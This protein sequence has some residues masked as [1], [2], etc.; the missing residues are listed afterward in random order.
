VGTIPQA[1]AFIPYEQP[2]PS[3]RPASVLVVG[4]LGI[5][6]ASIALAY[7]V[8]SL[9]LLIVLSRQQGFGITMWLT[10]EQRVLDVVQMIASWGFHS[11]LLWAS[12]AAIRL[13]PWA[14]VGL[15]RWAGAYLGWLA[16]DTAIRAL[17]V[18]PAVADFGARMRGGP[19]TG[20][21][22]VAY[23]VLAVSVVASM[24]YPVL[25][26]VV[27]RLRHVRAEFEFDDQAPAAAT[28][29]E[30]PVASLAAPA[31]AGAGPADPVKV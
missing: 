29:A 20:Q 23:G 31:A 30:V 15:L 13:R 25:A 7:L 22:V 4:I 10:P 28:A 21:R 27:M 11:V 19:A 5:V 17:W 24:I 26:I 9:A 3:R 14:R 8:L 16:A 18:I 12:I 6:V 1:G 2:V